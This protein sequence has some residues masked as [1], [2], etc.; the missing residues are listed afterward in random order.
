MRIKAMHSVGLLTTVTVVGLTVSACGS[1]SD[2]KA[3]ADAKAVSHRAE[4]V[5]AA[6]DG[7]T[8]ADKWRAGYYPMGDVV[9]LP[10]GGL[11]SKV[12]EQAYKDRSFVLRGKLPTDWP[13]SGR[14]NWAGDESLTRPLSGA[15]ESYR[16]LSGGLA[17]GETGL[18]VTGAK[19][20]TMTLATSRG[21]A[22]VPAWLFTLDGYTSPLKR[23]AADPSQLPPSPIGRARDIPV[24]QLNGLVDIAEDGR[25]V[26]VIALRGV[27]HDGATVEALET[28][29][30]VVLSSSVK[31]QKDNEK[32]TKQARLRQVSVELEHPLGDRILLDAKSGQPVPY[33]PPYG[34]SPS[35]S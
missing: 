4:Q 5:A 34:P 29:R 35:W 10:H 28:V 23:A 31:Q 18:T 27:C 13:K 2:E 32:C 1:Q 22:T 16:S 20:G 26:T 33:K 24:R 11:R 9:Q 21:P 12:D 3:E 25:S 15:E 6:W 7:S 8:A 30:S 19:L 17:D 14:V